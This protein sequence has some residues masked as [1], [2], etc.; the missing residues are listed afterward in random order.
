MRQVILI[1]HLDG[2]LLVSTDKKMLRP[3]SPQITSMAGTFSLSEPTIDPPK[4]PR[5]PHPEKYFG[6]L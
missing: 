6:P 3:P 5:K 2:T 4:E 1:H